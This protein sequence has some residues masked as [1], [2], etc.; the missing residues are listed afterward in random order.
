MVQARNEKSSTH[1][2]PEI[3]TEEQEQRRHQIERNQG[4]I[5][6]LDSWKDADEDEIHEQKET[7]EWLKKALDE[8]RPSYRK[9]FPNE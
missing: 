6:L 1:G 4:L 2:E 9:L 5:A 7:W 3:S 8:D